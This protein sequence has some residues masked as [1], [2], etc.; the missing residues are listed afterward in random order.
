MNWFKRKAPAA[1]QATAV[2]FFMSAPGPGPGIDISQATTVADVLRLLGPPTEKWDDEGE[3]FLGYKTPFGAI[4]FSCQSAI[5][6][7]AD[8]ATIQY[9]ELASDHQPPSPPGA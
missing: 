7:G 4:E 2:R 9:V 3:C 6:H 1:I 8:K 5:T